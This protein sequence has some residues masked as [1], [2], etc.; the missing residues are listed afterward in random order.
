MGVRWLHAQA[1][2]LAPSR[3]AAVTTSTAVATASTATQTRPTLSACAR[4][5][6][7]ATASTA[8]FLLHRVLPVVR[9]GLRGAAL[10]LSYVSGLRLLRAA[11]A[12][13]ASQGATTS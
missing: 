10:H 13:K 2:T 3:P 7:A 12:S 5:S 1:S 6:T 4:A 11:T 8:T 9:S